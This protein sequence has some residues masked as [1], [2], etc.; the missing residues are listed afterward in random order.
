M[1]GYN[2][3]ILCEGNLSCDWFKSMGMGLMCDWVC[4]GAKGAPEHGMFLTCLG[5]RGW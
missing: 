4:E 1:N 5:N 3:C 2:S